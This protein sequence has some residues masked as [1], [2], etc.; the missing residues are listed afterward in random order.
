MRVLTTA[1][2]LS[3]ALAPERAAGRTIG[4]VPTMGF[5]HEGHLGLCDALQG[6]CDVLVLSVF[7]NPLQF[8]PAEDLARYPRDLE[9]D[10]R[11]AAERGVHYVYAP[12]VEDMYPY[13]AAHVLVSA[14]DLSNRLCGAFRPG[15]F[16]GVLTVVAKLFHRV[17]P[18]VAIFG[19]KDLQQAALIRRMV[20][21]LD[22]PVQVEVAPIAREPDGL[23]RSS[24]NVYLSPEERQAALALWRGLDRARAAFAGGITDATALADRVR[25]VLAEEPLVRPQYVEVVDPDTLAPVARAVPGTALALAAFVGSTRL[26]DNLILDAGP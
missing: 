21:E 25:A 4:L 26:I 24:R 14:P 20:Q 10:V 7:V 5:L 17:A 23:A 11:L 1:A 6:R 9:R 15:H 2:E 12:A 8:G 3:A 13:G 19:Q 22:F 18:D 16:E